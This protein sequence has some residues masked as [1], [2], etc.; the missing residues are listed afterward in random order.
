MND[1]PRRTIRHKI[2]AEVT[3]RRS[4]DQPYKVKLRDLSQHGCSVELVNHVQLRE[5]LWI[6][7][8]GLDSIEGVVCWEE[9]FH[10][11]IDFLTP[12]HPAVF[13]MLLQKYER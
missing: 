8:P 12:L 3:L 1:S 7:L 6:K 10:A 5:R 4:L 11:G 13:D 2:D 9:D